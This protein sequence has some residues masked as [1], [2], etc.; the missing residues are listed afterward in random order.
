MC[1]CRQGEVGKV[2]AEA[3]AGAKCAERITHPPTPPPPTRGK[4]GR[5]GGEG[6]GG[7]EGKKF[8]LEKTQVGQKVCAKRESCPGSRKKRHAACAGRQ[9]GRML[10]GQAKRA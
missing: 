8:K 10:P 6:R 3:R 9:D 5:E 2:C 1:V 7:E 4:G